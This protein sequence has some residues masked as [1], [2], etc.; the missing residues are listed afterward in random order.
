MDKENVTHV[1]F[2]AVI[3]HYCGKP[4]QFL[5][6][7]PVARH[8]WAGHPPRSEMERG[9]TT[10]DWTQTCDKP[11]CKECAIALSEDVHICSDC[12]ERVTSRMKYK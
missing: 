3:C 9:N 5:C 1:D 8:R 2:N 10:M 11:V 7:M 12:A 6:D 4:A